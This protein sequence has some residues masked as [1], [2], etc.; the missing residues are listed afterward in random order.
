MTLRPTA[1]LPSVVSAL[2]LRQGDE[3]TVGQYLPEG[4][5]AF[6][7]VMNPVRGHGI[8]ARSWASYAA[9]FV[10]V[11]A[12]TRWN[13]LVDESSQ[14]RP[15]IGTIDPEL[16]VTLSQILRSHTR[17]PTDCYFLV[18]EGYAGLRAD[19]LT[20]ASVE[21]PFGRW[22]FVL[23]GDL[24]DGSETVGESASGRTAQWWLPADGAWAVGNDLYSASVY[25][26]GSEEL[27]AEVLA[28]HDI[29]AYRA[30]ASMVIVTEE[31]E[32]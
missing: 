10:K 27:I 19:V 13:D 14:D 18:W 6:A 21:L 22:M 25:I 2:S 8:R 17:T 23:A 20:A 31:F 24:R 26:S 5:V 7:R 30:T 11:D 9:G 16:A 32:S 15:D 29:E 1:S 28:A 4:H 3:M 12:T